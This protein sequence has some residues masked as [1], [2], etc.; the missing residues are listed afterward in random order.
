M[1]KLLYLQSSPRLERSYSIAVADAFVEE[2]RRV[3]PQDEIAV[4]NVFA[5]NLPTFDSIEVNA[6]YTIMHGLKHSADEERAWKRVEEVITEFKSADK[7]VFAVPMW[8]FGIPYRLKQFFDIII[9]PGYTFSYSPETGYKGLLEG[10]KLFIVY[11]R[12]GKYPEGS[13]REAFDLQKKYLELVFKFIGITDSYSLILEPTLQEGAE[14]AERM[15]EQAIGKAKAI[16][17]TF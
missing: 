2:Y 1:S 5:M 7:Y 3:N 17:K 10:K 14:I 15:K 11:A 8:N 12:G 13:E 4:E 6:K 16:A 9:Q